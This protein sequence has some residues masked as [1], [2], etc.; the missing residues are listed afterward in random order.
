MP[1]PESNSSELPKVWIVPMR[2]AIY[3][4]LASCSGYINFNTGKLDLRIT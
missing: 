3:S 4:V 2:L 1:N